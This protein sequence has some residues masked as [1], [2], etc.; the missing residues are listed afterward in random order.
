MLFSHLVRLILPLISSNY[1]F[2]IPCSSEDCV[3]CDVVEYWRFLINPFVLFC[4]IF[5]FW[6]ILYYNNIEFNKMNFGYNKTFLKIFG[7]VSALPSLSRFCFHLYYV[8]NKDFLP[9]FNL[10]AERCSGRA[11]DIIMDY[12]AGDNNYHTISHVSLA[13]IMLIMLTV[14]IYKI[15]KLED[16]ENFFMIMIRNILVLSSIFIL[17]ILTKVVNDDITIKSPTLFFF[18]LSGEAFLLF[19][20]F[21]IG[22]LFYRIIFF[23]PISISKKILSTKTKPSAPE[24]E[25]SES[26]LPEN[27]ITIK[28]LSSIRDNSITELI[29][30][31]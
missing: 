8:I 1:W 31:G 5:M 4:Y 7:I 22:N 30:D 18:T 11:P 6:L 2:N 23:V 20:L 19:L 28:K 24:I 17:E 26:D 14:K 16:K 29:I 9:S 15:Y 21:P 10:R 13:S 25:L 27:D 12:Y 3:Y